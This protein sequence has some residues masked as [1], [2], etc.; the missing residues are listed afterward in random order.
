M[1]EWWTY[2]PSDFLMYS[3][4]SW[5]RLLEGLHEDLWP[6]QVLVFLLAATALT[7]A[8]KRPRG[9]A[10]QVGGL[11]AVAWGW[12]AW[13]FF[14][15]RLA[16]INTAAQ[17]MAAGAA[18]QAVLL[19]AL[20]WQLSERDGGKATRTVGLSLALAALLLWPLVA[21]LRGLGWTQSE[22]PGL[23][24]DATA[25][26]AIGLLLALPLRHRR[27]LLAVPLV[28]LAIGATMQWLLLLR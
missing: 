22:L 23:T 26:F 5:G 13:D 18:L 25:L 15:N 28:L 2:R 1:S 17:W 12:I 14:W 20:G 9:S 21:P 19:A 24:P 7:R 10:L 6:W 8:W 16:Q 11:L 4:R 27:W 3:P